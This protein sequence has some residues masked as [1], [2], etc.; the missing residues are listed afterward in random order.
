MTRGPPPKTGLDDAMSAAA[1]RGTVL[2]FVRETGN[3]CD[4]CI[5]GSDKLILISVRKARRLSN[6]HEEVELEFQR[7]IWGLRSFPS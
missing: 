7:N 2:R 6:D 1:G 5:I 4:H 3:P